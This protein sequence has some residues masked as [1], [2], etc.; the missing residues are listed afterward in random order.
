MRLYI[1]LIHKC[2]CIWL[3]CHNEKCKKVE[4]SLARYT[5]IWFIISV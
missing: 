4:H 1:V 5:C 2:S 3:D